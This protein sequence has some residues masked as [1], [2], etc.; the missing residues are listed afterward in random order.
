[1]KDSSAGQ[2][3]PQP[4]GGQV[5]DPVERVDQLQVGQRERHGVDGEVSSRQVGFDGGREGH[6]RLA[7]A[8]RVLLGAVG[9]D[10]DPMAVFDRANGAE[11][12]AL[13]PDAVPPRGQDLLRHLRQGIGGEIEVAVRV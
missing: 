11:P 5:V 6:V 12:L 2:R 4:F 3:G 8:S 1:M 13:R 10:L 7:R 9:G